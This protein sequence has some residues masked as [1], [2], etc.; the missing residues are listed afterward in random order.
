MDHALAHL[1]T[2]PQKDKSA[3][4]SSLLAATLSRQHVQSIPHDLHA[5]VA[6]VLNQDSGG[7]VVGR[8]V[9]AEL[10]KALEQGAIKDRQCRK[11]VVQSTLD[12]VRPRIVNYEEQVPHFPYAIQVLVL[13][14]TSPIH[15][16]SNWPIS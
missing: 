3:A 11:E 7:L 10:V 12:A 13:N 5:L 1:A 6:H 9:L 4:Y 14:T 2:L 16:L 8:H 15:C